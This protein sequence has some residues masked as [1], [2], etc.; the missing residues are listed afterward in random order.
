MDGRYIT[1][2]SS[3]IA[4]THKDSAKAFVNAYVFGAVP[5]IL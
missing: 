5:N 3:A 4:S 2:G 1:I